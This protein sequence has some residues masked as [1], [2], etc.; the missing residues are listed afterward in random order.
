MWGKIQ[1]SV[2][3][4]VKTLDNVHFMIAV[5]ARPCRDTLVSWPSNQMG[6]EVACLR[7]NTHNKWVSSPIYLQPRL[8]RLAVDRPN[9]SRGDRPR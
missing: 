9:A 3:I 4:P 8:E 6:Q 1:R 2:I 5:G 7:S